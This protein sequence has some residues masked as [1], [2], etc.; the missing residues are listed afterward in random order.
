[1]EATY[2]AGSKEPPAHY[3]PQQEEDFLVLSG[4]LTVKI[5]G[6]T[7]VLQAGDSLHIPAGQSHAMWNNRAG[8]TVV[9]WKVRPAMDTDKLLETIAGLAADGK[10]NKDGMPGILQVSLMANK[11][12]REFRLSGP[13]FFLQKI[14]FI[15][16][17][18]LA[19]L[20]GYRADYKKYSE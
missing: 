3:H 7:R 17:S 1:M 19:Y 6:E 9:N 11:Y 18:P 15:L 13:P 10:T 12:A 5:T 14:V 16:L 4:E 2:H 8:I 20:A